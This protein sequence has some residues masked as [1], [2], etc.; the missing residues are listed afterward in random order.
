MAKSQEKWQL[1]TSVG[2]PVAGEIAV[3]GDEVRSGLVFAAAHIWLWRRSGGIIEV[4][5]QRRAIDKATWPG[6]W[7]ISAAG[8]VNAGEGFVETALREVRE[9]LSIEVDR[10]S[11]RFIFSYRMLNDPGEINSVYLCEMMDDA[12]LAFTDGEVQD[13]RWVSLE[14][15][16]MIVKCPEDYPLVPQGEAYFTILLEN[17]RSL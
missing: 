16:S 9:E 6:Y 1:F 8:H 13:V 11:L 5:L 3:R 10:S 2:Q 15:L 12:H 17:L 4:L 7:D 14:D